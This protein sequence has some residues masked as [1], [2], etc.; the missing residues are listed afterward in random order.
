MTTGTICHSE[1][2]IILYSSQFSLYYA[3]IF[4]LGDVQ[5]GSM[6]KGCVGDNSNKCPQRD[7]ALSKITKKMF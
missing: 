5:F 2:T 6:S 4:N 1:C 7:F 3:P